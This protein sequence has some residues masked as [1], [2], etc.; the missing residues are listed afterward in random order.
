MEWSKALPKDPGLWLEA[1]PPFSAPVAETLQEW[2]L[3]W[4]PDLAVSIKWTLLCF[5]GRKL[6]CGL[7]ACQRHLAVVFFRGV[8]LPD[9][10]GLFLPAERN[11]TTRTIRILSLESLN[12]AAFRTLLRAAVEL[13]ADP[14]V[15]P[16]PRMRR[17]PWP[18]PPFF[19]EALKRRTNRAAADQFAK[20]APSCQRE[21]LVWLSSAK[22]PETREKRLAETLA[23]LAAGRRWD[24][25]KR[26]A[27]TPSKVSGCG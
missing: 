8:E 24:Q 13:D 12:R 27:K 25:R 18:V 2:I 3:T 15:P 9:P 23:A 11:V 6:I 19:A 16:P 1:C 26:P 22:R 7:N 10:A 20:L 21:Y 5:S 4:E 17:E 14:T